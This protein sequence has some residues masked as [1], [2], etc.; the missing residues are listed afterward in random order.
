MVLYHGSFAS[1]IRIN[2]SLSTAEAIEKKDS[3]PI[4]KVIN[5][6]YTRLM[7]KQAGKTSRRSIQFLYAKIFSSYYS[8][9]SWSNFGK[10]RA[11]I[12]PIISSSGCQETVI[13]TT[14]YC[15]PSSR[16]VENNNSISY[17]LASLGINNA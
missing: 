5:Q 17:T 15:F 9:I 4:T 1:G 16:I 13:Q 14:S 12:I 6:I 10:S 3:D 2:G 7:S 8:I 11:V